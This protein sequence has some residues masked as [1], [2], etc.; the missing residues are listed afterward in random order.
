MKK[1]K[2]LNILLIFVLLTINLD[3]ISLKSF[4]N[5][6]PGPEILDMGGIVLDNNNSLNLVKADVLFTIDS[7]DFQ[8][9]ISILFD[10]HYS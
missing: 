6:L 5:P 10:G 2:I 8:N 3:V 1:T 4:A 9:N 7:T